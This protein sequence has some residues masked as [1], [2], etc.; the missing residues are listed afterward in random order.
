M[1]IPFLIVAGF[2]FFLVILSAFVQAGIGAPMDSRRTLPVIE[3]PSAE[4]DGL[5]LAE[6]PSQIRHR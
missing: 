2:G 6:V 1:R 5:A 3:A 4:P